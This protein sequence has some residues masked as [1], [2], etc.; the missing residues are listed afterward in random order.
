MRN[1][2]N[3]H[4][5]RGESSVNAAVGTLLSWIAGKNSVKRGSSPADGAAGE[6]LS[7]ITG[8]KNRRG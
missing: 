3:D 5:G 7:W 8:K 1:A 2:R 6:L 4:R